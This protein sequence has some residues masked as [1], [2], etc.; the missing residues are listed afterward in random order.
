MIKRLLALSGIA[1]LVVSVVIGARLKTAESI[2]RAMDKPE[3]LQGGGGL[4]QQCKES[5]FKIEEITLSN[6]VIS[7]NDTGSLTIV[8]SNNSTEECATEVSLRGLQVDIEPSGSQ[9]FY[10]PPGAKSK[11]YVWLFSPRKQGSF[12]LIV[13]AIPYAR[14]VGITVTNVWGLTARQASLLSL[15]GTFLGPSLTLPGL[16]ALVKEWRAHNENPASR[17]KKDKGG[18]K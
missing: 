4:S 16:W 10:V 1:L 18:R 9:S 2:A 3:A 15:L 12:E 5:F 17:R 6:R 11:T 13:E 14:V 7:E 8:L